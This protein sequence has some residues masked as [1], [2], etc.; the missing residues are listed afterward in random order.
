MQSKETNTRKI[1]S[2]ADY[3][4]KQQQ[5][6]SGKNVFLFLQAKTSPSNNLLKWPIKSTDQ[7]INKI[8]NQKNDDDYFDSPES[9]CVDVDGFFPGWIHKWH[10]TTNQKAKSQKSTNQKLTIKP[11][12]QPYNFDCIFRKMSVIQSPNHHHHFLLFCFVVS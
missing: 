12:N 7:A 1:I 8:R 10:S 2:V 5:K 3:S 11:T 9:I 4:S 6:K